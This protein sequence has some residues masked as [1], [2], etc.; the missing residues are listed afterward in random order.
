MT[1]T[2]SS[3]LTPRQDSLQRECDGRR[4]RQNPRLRGQRA[5]CGYGEVCGVRS[6]GLSS[7]EKYAQLTQKLGQLQPFIA[8]FPQECVG[9]LP[10][11]W[12]NLTP[13]SLTVQRGQRPARRARALCAPGHSCHDRPRRKPLNLG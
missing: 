4:P 12:A 6:H 7:S 2:T 5:R 11:F 3:T 8:V 1:L 13:L 10:V 9:H